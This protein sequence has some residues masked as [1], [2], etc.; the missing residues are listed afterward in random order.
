MRKDREHDYLIP[1]ENEDPFKNPDLNPIWNEPRDRLLLVIDYQ[2]DFIDGSLGFDG[3]EQIEGVIYRKVTRYM[4]AGDTVAYT[5]DT[6]GKNYLET[7]EGRALPI[8]HCIIDTPGWQLPNDRMAVRM[9]GAQRFYKGTFGCSDLVVWM[10]RLQFK[11][12]E[13]CGLVT[14]QC[15]LANA[16]LARCALPEARVFVDA[17]AVASP[18]PKLAQEA[19]DVM[20]GLQI[21]VLR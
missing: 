6:H 15:V 13:L 16:V 3:A 10:K 4:I 14:H 1:D 21:E 18:D 19:F 5:L 12:V 11:E 20:E 7:R 2:K 8:E 9:H 17:K